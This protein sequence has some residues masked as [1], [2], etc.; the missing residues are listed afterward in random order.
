MPT[1]PNRDLIYLLLL[2]LGSSSEH[3]SPFADTNLRVTVS[4]KECEKCSLTT[5]CFTQNLQDREADAASYV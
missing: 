3:L 1:L 5:F 2:S 4:Y